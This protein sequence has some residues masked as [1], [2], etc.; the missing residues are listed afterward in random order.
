MSIISTKTIKT[1]STQG[2]KKPNIIENTSADFYVVDEARSNNPFENLVY[3][4]GDSW[5]DKFTPIPVQ[6]VN[7]LTSIKFPKYTGLVDV[8]HIGDTS[9]DITTKWQG[10]RTKKM[11]DFYPFDLILLSI[12]GNDMT[13]L[14]CDNVDQAN[15]SATINEIES[16]VRKFIAMRDAA[17]NPTTKSAPILFHGYDYFQPRPSRSLIFTGSRMGPGPWV[18]TDMK[19]AGYSDADMFKYV[20]NIL[21]ALNDAYIQI[22]E[23]SSNVHFIDQRGTLTIAQPGSVGESGDWM[24]EIHASPDGY[25]KLADLLWNPAIATLMR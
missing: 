8:S 1:I 23:S 3:A 19:N 20:A 15:V 5:F 7:I 14:L 11:F 9:Y 17:N 16:N 10:P 24:D 13:H 4:E 22:A 18:Y 2:W 21:D 25:A 6:G 12:G